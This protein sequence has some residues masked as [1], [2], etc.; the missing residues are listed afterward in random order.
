[1][2][3]RGMDAYVLLGDPNPQHTG[4]TGRVVVKL[5]WAF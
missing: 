4:F 5:I 2:V 1:V 3:R